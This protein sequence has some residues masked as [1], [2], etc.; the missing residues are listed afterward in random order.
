MS[1]FTP[2][3]VKKTVIVSQIYQNVYP[4]MLLAGFPPVPPV[5]MFSFATPDEWEQILTPICLQ[6]VLNPIEFS[7]EKPAEGIE[8]TQ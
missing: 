1:D 5:K 7:T 2:E 6:I 8:Q 4:L 3:S